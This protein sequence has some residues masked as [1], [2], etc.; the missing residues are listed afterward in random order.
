MLLHD[1][2]PKN[3]C[4]TG[5]GK[6]CLGNFPLKEEDAFPESKDYMK[7]CSL[8]PRQH[9]VKVV[10]YQTVVVCYSNFIYNRHSGTWAMPDTLENMTQ[11]Q[12]TLQL[13]DAACLATE[14]TRM[15][16]SKM[17]RGG[18]TAFLVVIPLH[19]REHSGMHP[20]FA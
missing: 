7:S 19:V 10:M 17:M 14:I 16:N 20:Q 8:L 2:N 9:L 15:L 6:S 3:I 1:H 18:I 12:R 4:V 13:E 5:A 11:K